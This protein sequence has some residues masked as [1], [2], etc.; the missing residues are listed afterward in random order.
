M[1]VRPHPRATVVG[2]CRVSLAIPEN[3]SLKGKRSIVRKIIEQARH[4]F[5]VSA[6][7]ID[8]MDA[9]RM[10]VLGFAVI[11]ND[12]RH[13]S[14]VLSHVADFVEGASEAVVTDRATEI[15]YLH[16]EEGSF[17]ET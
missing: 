6:A 10:A 9:H 14:S 7:E 15:L 16:P 3:E 2:I 4:R 8:A 12:A 17:A 5:S 1:G 11:S 13:A